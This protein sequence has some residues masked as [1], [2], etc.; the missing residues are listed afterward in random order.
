MELTSV[1]RLQVGTHDP[2]FSLDYYEQKYVNNNELATCH[3]VTLN[4][5]RLFSH[6]E[7]MTWHWIPCGYIYIY[8]SQV[9]NMCSMW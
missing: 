6:I 5:L 1:K 7:T 2:L 9:V 3:D 8:I 4:T